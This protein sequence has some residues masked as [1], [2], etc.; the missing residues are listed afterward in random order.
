MLSARVNRVKEDAAG[1]SHGKG[2]TCST[3]DLPCR[4]LIPSLPPSLSL[5]PLIGGASSQGEDTE[6]ATVGRRLIRGNASGSKASASRNP[7]VAFFRSYETN[8][9]VQGSQKKSVQGHPARGNS[10]SVKAER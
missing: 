3:F 4:H 8:K 1:C 5:S 2:S 9:F 10:T 6:S 7:L